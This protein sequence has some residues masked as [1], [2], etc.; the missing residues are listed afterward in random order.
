MSSRAGTTSNR[1]PIPPHLITRLVGFGTNCHS[2][3]RNQTIVSEMEFGE[4]EEHK[5][6]KQR[7]RSISRRSE[8]VHRCRFRQL[9]YLPINISYLILYFKLYSCNLPLQIFDLLQTALKQRLMMLV[10]HTYATQ[11]L[12]PLDHLQQSFYSISLYITLHILNPTL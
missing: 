10:T 11:L 3:T 8:F 1:A 6:G 9:A 4:G 12:Q 2:S 5:V 7:R